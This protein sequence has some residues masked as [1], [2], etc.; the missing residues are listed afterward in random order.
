MQSCRPLLKWPG[1]K[2]AELSWIK[3]LIPCHR[4]YFEPFFGG[5]SVFFDAV[6]APAYAND[7]H[8]DL[9]MFY[10]CVQEQNAAFFDLLADFAD[11][12]ESAT[13][14]HRAAMYY[15]TRERYN[16]A[17]ASTPYRAACFFLIRQFAYG[18]MFRVNSDGDF[19]VPFGRAYAYNNDLPRGK[20]EY[21]QSPPVR[22]KM[23]LLTLSTLDFE[24]FLNGFELNE[25]D[26][27]FL[28]PPYD[29]SFS[30]YHGDFNEQ[31]QRRL[32]HCL[33]GLT[34]KFMLVIK[35]TTLIESLYMDNGYTVRE[36]DLDYRFNIKGRFSRTSKHVLIM[37]YDTPSPIA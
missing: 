13:L 7:Q 4:R 12:W 31:D 15:R 8:P 10:A 32:A 30:K 37:N 20:V 16:A 25:R 21:L 33:E 9:I 19:N 14:D 34:G 1:G 5:G 17:P 22:E 36:Y 11:E 27:V 2:R 18:G 28:D 3:P 6:T 23:R 24:E 26:F 35:L 29:S